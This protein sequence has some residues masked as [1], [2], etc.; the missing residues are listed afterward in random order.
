MLIVA[1]SAV[2]QFYQ[3]KQLSP[4][5]KDARSLRSILKEAGQGKQADQSELNAATTRSMR[6]LLPGMIFLFTVNLASALALYWLVSGAVA[7]IQQTIILREDTGEMEAE[8]ASKT[9]TGTVIEG[10][11]IE[12]PEKKKKLA[13]KATTKKRRKK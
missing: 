8:A 6:Y 7:L 3:S 4:D 5:T 13:K 1:G 2:V 11:V 12:K 9:T 10:E